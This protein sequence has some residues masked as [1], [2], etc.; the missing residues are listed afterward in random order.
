MKPIG[1]DKSRHA[2]PALVFVY[3][4]DSGVFN[5]LADAAHKI[6]SPQTYRC[7]LCALTHT[8]VGMRREWKRFL[9]GLDAPPEFLH[10]DELRAR[11]GVEGVPLPA[12]FKRGGEKLEV[13]AGAESIN[14]CRTLDDLKRLILQ[15]A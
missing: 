1:G 7:N 14:A 11:Y 10:A 8:A 12:V 3:N 13:V 9:N 15:A 4:A 2:R 6:F 5:T